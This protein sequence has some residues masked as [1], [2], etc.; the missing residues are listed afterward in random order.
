[1]RREELFKLKI[2]RFFRKNLFCIKDDY[3]W[4][5]DPKSRLYNKF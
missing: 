1:M 3:S 5:D 4:C 2:N